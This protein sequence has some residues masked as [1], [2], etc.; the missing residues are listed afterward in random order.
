[1]GSDLAGVVDTTVMDDP[2]EVARIAAANELP[3]SA[4][5]NGQVQAIIAFL[6][7]LTDDG[8]LDGRLGVPATVPSGLPVDQ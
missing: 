6:G 4:L 5:S 3:P 2:A 1:M 8:S 7:A